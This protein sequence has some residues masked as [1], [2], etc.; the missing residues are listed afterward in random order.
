MSWVM[1]IA[2]AIQIN[3]VQAASLPEILQDIPIQDTTIIE[4]NALEAFQGK[5]WCCFGGG[6]QQVWINFLTIPTE[7]PNTIVKDVNLIVNLVGDNQKVA[8]FLD[9]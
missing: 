1:G 7:T 5:N 8:V 4:G 2:M 9:F 6:T 3:S